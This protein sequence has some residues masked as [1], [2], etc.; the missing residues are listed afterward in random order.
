M[1]GI[2]ITAKLDGFRR[3]GIAH[4]AAGTHY[5]EGYFSEAQ[6][7]A[8]R[9]EPQLV[10]VEGAVEA[11]GDDDIELRL[12]TADQQRELLSDMV[13]SLTGRLTDAEDLV[14]TLANA[15]SDQDTQ[16]AA[17]PELIVL[18]LLELERAD[19]TQQ[20]VLCLKADDVVAVIKRFTQALIQNPEHGNAG[21]TTAGAAA[22]TSETAPEAA[23]AAPVPQAPTADALSVTDQKPAGGKAARAKPGKD[24]GKQEGDNA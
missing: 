17:M 12:L 9:Q 21:T 7:E 23:S 6:L 22:G 15:L 19:P 8:F 16:L 10:V 4:S 18:D 2:T 1:S 24:A 3:G 13:E 5:P 14:Q 20:G 11:S